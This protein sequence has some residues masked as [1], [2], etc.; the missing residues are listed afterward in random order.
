MRMSWEEQEGIHGRNLGFRS[1]LVPA[2]GVYVLG[3]G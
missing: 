2:L 1:P 3:T